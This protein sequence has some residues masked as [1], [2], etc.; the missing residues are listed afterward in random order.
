MLET[1]EE[2]PILIPVDTTEEDV[3]LVARKFSGISGPGGTESEALQG[4]PLKF[5]EDSTRLRNSVENF[6][7]WLANGNSP[8][9]AYR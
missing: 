7:D 4:W 6:V 8:W 5:G 2:T 9:A 1:Y 3:E